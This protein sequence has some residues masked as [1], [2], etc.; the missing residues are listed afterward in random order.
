[1]VDKIIKYMTSIPN[2]KL[3]HSFYGTLIYICVSFVDSLFALLVA[4]LI[5][6]VKEVYDRVD[7]GRFDW[8]DIA[9]TVFIP[10]L[11]F[12]KDKIQ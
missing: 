9:A 8:K 11:L 5:A 7:Y 10:V 12:A 1:M 3:L 2:D 4:A 6:I